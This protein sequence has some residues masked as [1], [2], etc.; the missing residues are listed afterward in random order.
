MKRAVTVAMRP[1]TAPE[2]QQALSL[3]TGVKWWLDPIEKT[4]RLFTID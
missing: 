4:L 1:H 2:K 3:E